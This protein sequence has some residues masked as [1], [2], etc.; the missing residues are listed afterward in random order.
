MN[1]RSFKVYFCRMAKTMSTDEGVF[2]A[3]VDNEIDELFNNIRSLSLDYLNSQ[4]INRVYRKKDDTKLFILLP[5]DQETNDIPHYDGYITGLIAKTRNKRP[6]ESDSHCKIKDLFLS[7]TS[8]EV[9]EVT[10]FIIDKSNNVISWV[11]NNHVTGINGLAEYLNVKIDLLHR[12]NNTP[13]L[14]INGASANVS[15]P[16]LIENNSYGKFRDNMSDI[17]SVRLNIAGSAEDLQ[18]LLSNNSTTPDEIDNMLRFLKSYNCLG[19]DLRLSLGRNRNV[20]PIGK[21]LV[22]FVFD[23]LHNKS[24]FKNLEVKGKIDD[25]SRI[26][27]LIENRFL[28]NFEIDYEGNYPRFNDIYNKLLQSYQSQRQAINQILP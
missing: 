17:R 11:A 27:D 22:E 21:R 12:R 7:D 18:G 3:F 23:K 28:F 4:E 26:L 5:G 1:S 20:P 9:T 14:L 2:H 24:G 25:A 13:R 8:N 10:Y 6:Y 19:I 16:F 15:F